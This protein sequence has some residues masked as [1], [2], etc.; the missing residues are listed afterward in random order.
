MAIVVKS[1]D[2]TAGDTVGVELPAGVHRPLL[3]V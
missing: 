2:V 3:P 1:G